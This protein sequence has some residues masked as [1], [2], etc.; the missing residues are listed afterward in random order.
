[1]TGPR[2]DG[3]TVVVTGAGQGVG[4]GI[5]RACAAEGANVVLAA[6]RAE[7]GEPVAASIRASG[8]EATCIVTDVTDRAA[9]AR[10]VDETVRRYGGL[11]VF[12]HNAYRGGS[13]HRLEDVDLELWTQNSRTAVWGSYYSAVLAYPHLRAAGRRGRLILITSPAGVE[14]SANIPV[15]SPV[16]AAQRAMAKGLSKEWGATGITVNC[17]APVAATPALVGAFAE[18][19]V[20]K[21]RVE[22]R[23]SLR[24]I[25]DPEADIGSVAVFLASDGGGYVTGQTIVCDGG[26]FMGL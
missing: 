9:M 8:G 25:G 18:N 10:C 5:A 19:P 24:R 22:A 7:T 6:R 15:Y 12:V 21:Q 2:L 14:G 13:P 16:K 11:E 3:R 4:E 20:L 17:I 1:V 26:S 23:T